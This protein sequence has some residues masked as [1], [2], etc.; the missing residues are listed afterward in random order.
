MARL[1]WKHEPNEK[2]LAR[3]GQGPRGYDLNFGEHKRIASVDMVRQGSKFVYKG[4]YW[5]CASDDALGITHHNTASN[6]VETMDEAKEQA[7]A[8]IRSCL[9]AKGLLK[10]K[11]SK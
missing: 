9:E 8:Y 7:E 4:W 6:P 1:T 3:V 11:A 10:P 5:S 2:G